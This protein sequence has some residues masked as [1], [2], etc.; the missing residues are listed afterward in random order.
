MR[1]GPPSTGGRHYVR[2]AAKRNQS[3][4]GCARRA[5]CGIRRRIADHTVSAGAFLP[6]DRARHPPAMTPAYKSSAARAPRFAPVTLP[7][8]VSEMAGPVF[9]HDVLGP[10]DNDLIRNHARDGDPIGPRIL[11]HGFLRD[12]SGRGVPGALI[13]IW[14]ANAGRPLPPCARS[15]LRTARSEFRRLRTDDHRRGRRLCLP[16]ASSRVPIPGPMASMTGVRRISISRCLGHGFAQRLITQMY[17]EGDPLISAL[18]HRQ[19][20]PVLRGRRQPDRA[21]GYERLPSPWMPAPISFDIVLRGRRS[22]L[23]E[24]RLEGNVMPKAGDPFKQ[25]PSADRGALSAYRLRA[26]SLRASPGCSPEDLGTDGASDRGRNAGQP[27][28][29]SGGIDLRRH[30]HAAARRAGGDLASRCRWRS[31]PAKAGRLIRVSPGWG[32]AVSDTETG[33]WVIRD[34]QTRARALPAM[35]G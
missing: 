30:G 27:G 32:R 20:D 21:A 18:S 6:L 9:G 29:R 35:A 34:D 33:V 13:E 3:A 16:H 5:P 2:P 19:H 1:A 23:F 15:L 11:I 26:Q 25:T 12:E 8:T 7:S 17:F 4:P 10:F 24:N 28:L 22:T 14:Q 31:I